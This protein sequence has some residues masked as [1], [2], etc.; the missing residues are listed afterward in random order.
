MFEKFKKRIR[1]FIKG[2]ISALQ[3]SQ[4]TQVEQTILANQY[5][6]MKKMLAP[7][8]MPSLNGV[9]FRVNSEFEEDGILLYIFSIIGTTNKCVVEI[10]AG[11]GVE[12]MA[13]NLII[14]HGWRGLLFDGDKGLV[15]AGIRFYSQNKSTF[16]HPPILK[17][18]WITRENIDQLIAENGFKGEIDLLSL[19]I[20]GNDYYLMEAINVI[21]PRVVICETNNV[22][23][24]NLALTIPY[25]DD[26]IKGEDLHSDF[27]SVS[28]LAMTKLLN[29]KGYRLIGS[30]RYGFNAIFM[31]NEIGKDYFPEVSVESVHSDTYTKLRTET[32]WSE[33]KDLPW[34]EI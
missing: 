13:A 2:E 7:G 34:V 23:P 14:N 22:I 25:K 5:R 17:Q 26:F 1:N 24:G 32:A 3:A 27:S 29:A 8:E 6:L 16:I 30:H 9:G 10:C 31:L 4:N 11:D 28:L 18:A 19:D 20:D 15:E 21:R 33:V 12:C